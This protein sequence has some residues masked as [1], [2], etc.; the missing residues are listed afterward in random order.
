LFPSISKFEETLLTEVALSH[1]ESFP[2]SMMRDEDGRLPLPEVLERRIHIGLHN[3]QT[4]L[5]PPIVTT[6]QP[7]H[8]DHVG[9]DGFEVVF[10]GN[11]ELEK[12][13]KSNPGYA[14]VFIVEYR[15]LLM[16]TAEVKKSG[17]S[18]LLEKI[19]G[20]GEKKVTNLGVEKVVCVG[21]NA[22]TPTGNDCKQMKPSQKQR[23]ELANKDH[24]SLA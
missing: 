6:L 10:N 12:Y 18:A 22:W 24:F 23:I 2:D 3:T 11:I 19:G 8:S 20:G 9:G 13:V 15:V 5:F 7:I 16:T 4:F 21:W 1:L 17:L 14:V